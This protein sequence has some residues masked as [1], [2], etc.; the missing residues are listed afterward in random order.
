MVGR[1]EEIRQLEKLYSS[2]RSEFVAIYGR[3]RVGKTYL[4][5]EVFKDR[6]VFWHTGV[7]PYDGAK[8]NLMEDQLRAFHYN[9]IRYGLDEP[10]CPKDWIE[11]FNMLGRLIEN[12][13]DLQGKKVI[14]IDELPW[15]DTARA[16]FVPAFENFFNDWVSKRDDILLVVCGSATS[17]IEDKLIHSK[18][19]LY[20][21]LT[22]TIHLKPFTLAECREYYLSIG[23]KMSEYD[24]AQ[25]YMILGGI[26]FYMS[27]FDKEFS[28]AKNVDRLFFADD[29]K[30]EDEFNLLL[31]SLFIKPEQYKSII[32]FLS[33]RHSGYTRTE[34]VQGT[35]L[36][37]GGGLTN[38]LKS[39]KAGNFIIDYIPFGEKRTKVHYRLSDSFC[40]FWLYFKENRAIADTE[41][42]QHNCNSPALN[43]WRGISFEELCLNNIRSIKKALE[44]G[45]VASNESSLRIKGDDNREGS[46]IDLLID[47]ADNVVNLCEMKF[48]NDEF[49]V[50]KEYSRK[51]NQRLNLVNGMIPKRKVVHMTLITTEGLAMNEYSG[52]F[53]HVITLDQLFDGQ[54]IL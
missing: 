30:L 19:G 1:I 45:G 28:L 53:Q 44:I 51:L 4:V 9:L 25:S 42:W 48:Y 6:M 20:R 22:D 39:L 41:Y 32:K 37:D 43:S 16:R 17:W 3:R 31:G 24:I 27:F 54:T 50:T 5:K 23:V 2:D 11:A 12:K 33:S 7:S 13:T 52:V 29:A 40:R 26:P 46:Q 21:R 38:Q 10:K 8:E 36:P 49:R 34:I 14:F 47:R 15:M 18:G 35:K